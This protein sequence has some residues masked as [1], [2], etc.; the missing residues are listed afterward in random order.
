MGRPAEVYRQPVQLNP[1]YDGEQVLHFDMRPDDPAA[2]L[3]RQRQRLAETLA[4]LDDEQWAAPS[5]CEHWT[6]QDVVSHL[7][8][9]N[10]F[11]AASVSSGRGGSPTRILATFD[12]V[13]TPAL[14]VDAS[15]GQAPAD[16]LG[17]FLESNE[18]LTAAVDG[19]DDETWAARAE[20]PLGHVG[21]DSVLLHALWD[22]WIHERD[23][24]LPLGLTPVEEPDEIAAC[25]RYVAGGTAALNAALGSTRRGTLA[26][27]A[28]DPEV[29]VV[30][31]LG[32]TVVVREGPPP[33]GAAVLTG[34]A[35]DLVEGLTF[36]IPLVHDLGPD[37][38]WMLDGLAQVF[39]VAG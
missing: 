14:L 2:L 11:W 25:L 23:V 32:P 29:Q 26:V 34:R 12:P 7:V 4:T 24:L 10:G 30:V 1:R 31:D 33:A 16:V 17:R 36:R 28:T 18:L 38:R 22:A 20:S 19:I 37:D 27:V 3:V 8:D 39:D 15:R 35:A 6:V 21:L 9:T 13:A 5:R